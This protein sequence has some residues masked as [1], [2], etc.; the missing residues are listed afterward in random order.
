[1]QVR[2]RLIVLAAVPLLPLMWC[3]WVLTGCLPRQAPPPSEIINKND[4]A[5]MALVPAGEFRRGSDTGPDP[6]RPQ[7][8]IALRAF[9]IDKY[10]VT[11]D[12]YRKFAAATG[13]PEPQGFG[14]DGNR[15]VTDFRPWRDSRFNKPDQPVVCV[16]WEDAAAYAA[17]AGKRLPTEAEWEKAARGPLAL[18]FPWG[19]DGPLRGGAYLANYDPSSTVEGASADADGYELTAPVGRFRDGRSPYE[20]FDMAG[21]VAEWCADWY[22]PNFYFRSPLSDPQGPAEGKFRVIRGGSWGSVEGDIRCA[23]RSG[24]APDFRHW[25]I[26]FRCVKD[27][28]PPQPRSSV[29]RRVSVSR[30]PEPAPE[31]PPAEKAP[32]APEPPARPF[33]LPAGG[34]LPIEK[35]SPRDGATLVLIPAGEFPMGHEEGDNDEKPVRRIFLPSFYLDKYPVTNAQYRKFVQ[36]TG[37]PEPVGYGYRDGHFVEDFRPWQDSRFDHPRMPVVCVSWQDAMDYALWAGRRLPTEA[38]W[39]KA[40]KGLFASTYPWGNT[41]PSSVKARYGLDQ[42]TGFPAIVGGHPAGA[43]SYGCMDMAGNVWE[44]CLDWYAE[45]TYQYGPLISPLGPREGEARALRGG[46]WANGPALL[47]CSARFC[48]PPPRKTFYIGFRCAADVGA[49]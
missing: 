33:S 11:N 29:W 16:S 30:A 35:A 24:G 38:E 36:E 43:S 40:A 34:D 14:F 12:Q 3:L 9:Y 8:A 46:S 7:R 22:D 19:N 28:E 49:E 5:Q 15:R 2:F 17:W 25:Y 18:G 23:A 44:W 21:N 32:P 39:E 42:E 45:T 1:M 13:R 27:A 47:R 48:Q 26:G 6:E 31:P 41:A 37:R 10:E 20:A 4:R